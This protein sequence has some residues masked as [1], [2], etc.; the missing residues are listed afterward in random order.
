MENIA[1]KWH[2]SYSTLSLWESAKADPAITYRR[3][4][5]NTWTDQVDYVEEKGS[6]SR[7]SPVTVHGVNTVSRDGTLSWRGKGFY[8]IFRC[9]CKVRPTA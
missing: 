7:L 6:Y 2:I 1:G 8:S 5:N 3:E 4:S 9:T